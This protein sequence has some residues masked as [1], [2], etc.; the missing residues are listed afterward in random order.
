MRGLGQRETR[1]KILGYKDTVIYR[2]QALQIT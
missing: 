2:I 1:I